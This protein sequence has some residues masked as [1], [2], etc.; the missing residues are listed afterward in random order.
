MLKSIFNWML[1]IGLIL[2]AGRIITAIC[3]FFAIPFTTLF[4][5][6]ALVSFGILIVGAIGSEVTKRQIK[7]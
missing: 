3:W 5:D 1:M 6:V 2:L 4:T 7:A